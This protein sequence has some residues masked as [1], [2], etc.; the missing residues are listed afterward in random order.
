MNKLLFIFLM[1]PS[2]AQAQER[3]ETIEVTE[4]KEQ[5]S[6]SEYWEENKGT[7]IYSGKK[8]T[9]TDLKKIP[10]LQTNNYRQATSQTPGHGNHPAIFGVVVAQLEQGEVSRVWVLHHV[11]GD[12]VPVRAPLREDEGSLWED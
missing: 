4:G 3:L 9:V 5:E 11:E 7:Q 12:H 6:F 10:Q 8:N 1:L 2:L